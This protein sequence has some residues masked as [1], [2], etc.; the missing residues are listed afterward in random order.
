MFL[1]HSKGS[2]LL[3][4]KTLSEEG[5]TTAYSGFILTLWA[6]SVILIYRRLPH[7]RGIQA[8]GEK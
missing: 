2:L 6:I 5:T 8:L 7:V 3:V 1:H 4:L